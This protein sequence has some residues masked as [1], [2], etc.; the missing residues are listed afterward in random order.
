MG[1]RTAPPVFRVNAGRSNLLYYIL[2]QG[3]PSSK[4]SAPV[5][6]VNQQNSRTEQTFRRIR[7]NTNVLPS[8]FDRK[9]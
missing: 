8:H 6:F 2:S 7:K 9:Q 5:I 3:H 4:D 1:Y